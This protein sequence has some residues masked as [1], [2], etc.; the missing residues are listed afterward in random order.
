MSASERFG[1]LDS[2]GYLA[3]DAHEE[4]LLEDVRTH[5]VDILM[6]AFPKSGALADV[7]AK[8]IRQI[9]KAALTLL[10]ELGECG[11]PLGLIESLA[12]AHGRLYALPNDRAALVAMLETLADIGQ[13]DRAQGRWWQASAAT[14][15]SDLEGLVESG[16]EDDI[17]F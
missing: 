15:A 17:P 8:A 6:K 3:A 16:A 12:T 4:D 13:V 1:L 9:L 7:K 11:A 2:F 5:A 14:T 10:K